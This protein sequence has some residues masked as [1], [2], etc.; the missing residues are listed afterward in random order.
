MPA[1][2]SAAPALTVAGVTVP[3]SLISLCVLTAQNSLLA[4]LLHYVCASLTL[5][6]PL[7]P[8][9]D[10]RDLPTR[11]QSRTAPDAKPFS[12]A[13]AVLLN[14]ILKGSISFVVAL[15]NVDNSPAP[16]TTSARYA[17]ADN[18]V[19]FLGN[20]E[21]PRGSGLTNGSK[22]T[23]S[24]GGGALSLGGVPDDALKRRRNN[25]KQKSPTGWA[26]SP[27]Q[28]VMRARRVSGML[29]RQVIIVRVR[30]ST[31]KSL[32]LSITVRT[33]G[34]WLSLQHAMSCRITYVHRRPHPHAA[35]LTNHII[36]AIRR[37]REL[38]RCDIPS[39]LPNEGKTQ[40]SL[41]Y[42]NLQAS[43]LRF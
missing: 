39:Q 3:Y 13:A 43:L 23:A 25:S 6:W 7:T 22:R 9:A 37:R 40:T 30:R 42:A 21:K 15:N 27:S 41:V 31:S 32:T 17:T 12:A 26:A 16:S 14:E 34:S 24:L 5:I 4:I 29:L 1:D 18:G 38:G 28:W 35:C 10:I 2:A 8:R 36:A 19:P 33:A 20:H 11:P